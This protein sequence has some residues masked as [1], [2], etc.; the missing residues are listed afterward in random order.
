MSREY[1]NL[2]GYAEGNK[3]PEYKA[4][5][6]MK[7]RCYNKNHPHYADYGGR[8]IS[9]HPE[10]IHDAAAF[11][12]HV[13]MRPSDKHSINR[14]DNDRGYEPGNVVWSTQDVQCRNRRNN[15]LTRDDVMWIRFCILYGATYQK[16]ADGFG[17]TKGMVCS[18][19]KGR[20][21]R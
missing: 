8:G 5:I 15:K 21:W 12:E 9:V 13:G 2:H 3:T 6:S 1:Y 14:M 18:I 20:T 4:W 10:W 7:K 19:V 17:I 11:I 16:I